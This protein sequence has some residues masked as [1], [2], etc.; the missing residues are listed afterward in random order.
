MN[1]LKIVNR[2][3]C[4]EF[5]PVLETTSHSQICVSQEANFAEL[6]R[7]VNTITR[8]VYFLVRQNFVLRERCL[9]WR[10]HLN[11]NVKHLSHRFRTDNATATTS[12]QREHD[13]K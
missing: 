12:S 9:F 3:K 8:V 13:V 2:K 10:K 7:N 1:S 4:W 5:K 6:V 11:L